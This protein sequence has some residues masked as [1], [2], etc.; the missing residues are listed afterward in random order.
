MAGFGRL[1]ENV[2]GV[3]GVKPWHGACAEH[4]DDGHVHRDAD[5][6]GAGI[7]RNEERTL[8]EERC[9]F[10]ER[11]APREGLQHRMIAMAHLGTAGADEFFIH[12]ASEEGDSITLFQKVIGG[13]RKIIVNP[14]LRLPTRTDVQG[15]NLRSHRKGV[16][17]ELRSAFCRA[18]GQP[19]L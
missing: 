10:C 18:F 12:R 19:H 15:D 7:R 3:V 2:L 11:D 9:K 14:A 17:P 1:Q 8:L 4:R 5:V 6:H 16:L 13:L